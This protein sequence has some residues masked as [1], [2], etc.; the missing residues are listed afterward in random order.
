MAAERPTFNDDIGLPDIHYNPLQNYRNVTYNT[1]L[2]MMPAKEAALE[3]PLRSYDFKKG[4]IMWE[5]GGAGTVFLEELQVETVGTGSA[6]GSYASQQFHN[7]SGKLVEPIG[8]RFIEALSLGAL[9][10]GYANNSGAVYLFEIYFSGYN[11]ESDMPEQCRGWDGEELIFR[12]YVTLKE[13]KMKLDYKG[14]TYDFTMFPSTAEAGLSDHTHLEQ[15][16]KMEGSPGTIGEF[17][18]Q[19]EKAL[20]DRE[21]EK[22]KSQQRCHAHVYK[23]SAHK[24]IANLKY[25]YGLFSLNTLSFG[26]YKGQIQVPS[27]TTI[28]SFVLSSMPNSKDILKFLHKIPEKKDFNST[29]TKKDTMHIIAK[30]FSIISGSKDRETAGKP[31]FDNRIGTTAKEVHYFITTKEDAKNV[32]GPQEYEDAWETTNRDKRVD[33]WI[34]KGLLR[35]V[36]KWIY[37]G[38][39]TEVINCDIKLDYLWRTVRP[40]WLDK[41]GKPVSAQSTRLAAKA[42]KGGSS[43]AP[44]ACVDARSVQPF[45]DGKTQLYVEDMP[46]REGQDLDIN[47][48]KGWYPHMPQTSIV[49]TTVQEGSGQGALSPESATEYSVYRQLGN[50]QATGVEDMFTMTLEVVGDPYW[51]FQIPGKPG[52]APWEEDVWEYEKEQ[53]TEDMMAEKRKKTASHNWLPFIYFQAQAPAAD[54]TTDDLMNLRKADTI[55]GIFSAKKV[56]N[57]FVKGKFT[58]T[59]E[60]FRDQL[61]NPWGKTS[62]KSTSSSFTPKAGTGEASATGPTNA[63]PAN[64]DPNA[65]VPSRGPNAEYTNAEA[66]QEANRLNRIQQERVASGATTTVIGQVP[67]EQVPAGSPVTGNQNPGVTAT[68]TASPTEAELRRRYG[69]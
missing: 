56:T 33:N 15:G 64:A 27:G 4:I 65:T 47:P 30:N 66:T 42:T 6:S 10:L 40:L 9:T 38:E 19:L 63:S 51:L 29:D 57:K 31:L 11:S 45:N 35:K 62:K 44:V 52:T 13:L 50:G 48:K 41:D 61:S 17:C 7:F 25:D 3:R 43:P 55:T 58:T 69:N 34:K 37:T 46:Y 12:W 22:V 24:E 26:M 21:K 23:I 59:L 28:Q 16:F 5:T 67:V 1:R 60:C 18:T 36:Y 20:N 14:S 54:L 8:G 2:T 53:L 32:I 68:R 39:N 49:N